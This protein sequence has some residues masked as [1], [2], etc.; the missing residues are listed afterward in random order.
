MSSLP[1]NELELSEFTSSFLA[2]SASNGKAE[3]RSFA[4]FASAQ[5]L[6]AHQFDKPLAYSQSVPPRWLL[7]DAQPGST[8]RLV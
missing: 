6:A 7:M 1:R 5:D 4:G 8:R 3:Y 2:T